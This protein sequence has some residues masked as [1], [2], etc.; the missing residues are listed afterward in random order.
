MCDCSIKAIEY[1]DKYVDNIKLACY[2]DFCNKT[3]EREPTPYKI[4]KTNDGYIEIFDESYN[5]KKDKNEEEEEEE[6]DEEDAYDFVNDFIDDQ[7]F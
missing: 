3:E 6:E 4:L 2:C 1:N 5:E 7:E